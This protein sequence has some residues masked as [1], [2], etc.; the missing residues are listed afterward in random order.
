M[1][2]GANFGNAYDLSEKFSD[3]PSLEADVEEEITY[4]RQ[5]L[6]IIQIVAVIPA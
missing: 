5:L 2:C 1:T 4:T 3:K 6:E